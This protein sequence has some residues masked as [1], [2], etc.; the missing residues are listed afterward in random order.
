MPKSQPLSK[1]EKRQIIAQKL[2][3]KQKKGATLA[4]QIARFKTA[5]KYQG[6]PTSSKIQFPISK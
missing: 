6:K 4:G 1:T 5:Q 2:I 3:I